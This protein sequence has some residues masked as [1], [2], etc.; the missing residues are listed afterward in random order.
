M[1]VGD[2]ARKGVLD[3]D[4]GEARLPA[5]HGGQRILE[6]RT[7]QRVEVRISLAAGKVRV[8]AGLALVRNARHA[9]AGRLGRRHG[10]GVGLVL[11]WRHWMI[12]KG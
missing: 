4:H 10:A 8:R 2:A 7:R 3:R 5:L 11:S 9:L 1:D 6:G 12:R